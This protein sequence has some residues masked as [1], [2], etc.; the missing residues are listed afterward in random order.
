MNR[1]EELGDGPA[2]LADFGHGSLFEGAPGPRRF[3]AT[4]ELSRRSHF[5]PIE[6]CMESDGLH[7]YFDRRQVIRSRAAAG[8]A[9]PPTRKRSEKSALMASVWGTLRIPY[10]ARRTA[11]LHSAA[12]HRCSRVTTALTELP[13]SSRVAGVDST[14]RPCSPQPEGARGAAKPS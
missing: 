5:M 8:S 1:G 7:A 10:R 3:C 4:A 11:I 9:K 14:L 2:P 6:I 13:T 12:S